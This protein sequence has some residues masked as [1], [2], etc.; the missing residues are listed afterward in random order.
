MERGECGEEHLKLFLIS[1]FLIL[2]VVL[3]AI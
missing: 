1:K 3:A 2:F